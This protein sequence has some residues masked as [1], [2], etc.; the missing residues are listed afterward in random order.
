MFPFRRIPIFN[1]WRKAA[2]KQARGLRRYFQ[3]QALTLHCF[4]IATQFSR[5]SEP[6][7]YDEVVSAHYDIRAEKTRLVKGVIRTLPGRLVYS[8][9]SDTIYVPT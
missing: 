9:H 6:V 4:L 2:N 7:L 1:H 8:A 5:S 3:R